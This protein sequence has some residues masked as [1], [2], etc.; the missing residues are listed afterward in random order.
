MNERINGALAVTAATSIAGDTAIGGNARVSGNLEVGGWLDAP[1]IR[2]PCKGLFPS[3][4]SLYR[5]YPCPRPGW[6]ALVGESLPAQI[7]RAAGREWEYTGQEGGQP[8]ADLAIYDS[9]I[10]ALRKGINTVGSEIDELSAEHPLTVEDT[11]LADLIIADERRNVI[12]TFAG[13]HI[14]TAKFDSANI[15]AS[16]A[17]ARLKLP[18]KW[19]A[20]G[21]SVSYWDVTTGE[22]YQTRVKERI[23]F[24]DYV[25]KAVGGSTVVD[26]ANAPASIPTADYYTIEHAINDYGHGTKLGTMTD[27]TDGTGSATFYGAYRRVIDRI[28][29]LNPQALIILLTPVKGS[30]PDFSLPDT[31]YAPINGAYMA[32][33]ADA[34]REIGRYCSLPVADV[35]GESNINHANRARMFADSYLHPNAAAHR[36]IAALVTEKFRLFDL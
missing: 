32:D 31:W 2:T 3:L 13:G 11:A 22:G 14:R 24:G 9:R 34:V 18:G 1:N 21:T 33:F 30:G 27:F 15:T 36:R 4:E 17:G 19:A 35:F 6:W 12:A 26:L 23:E 16:K 7:Y 10:D 20:L 5:A 25:N 28:Y 8:V 29:S